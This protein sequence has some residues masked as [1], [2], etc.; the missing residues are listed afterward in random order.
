MGR[1]GEQYLTGYTVPNADNERII[2][3]ENVFEVLSIAYDALAR[4]YMDYIGA[5]HGQTS[6][7]YGGAL[8]EAREV[9][10]QAFENV[11]KERRAYW[12]THEGQESE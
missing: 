4:L 8:S 3:A 11:G 10:N 7:I 12:L 9:L 5:N 2:E 1:S 6:L